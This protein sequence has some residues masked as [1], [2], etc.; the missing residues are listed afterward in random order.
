MVRED[1]TKIG[2][3]VTRAAPGLKLIGVRI[4]T[5]ASG[6]LALFKAKFTG[7]LIYSPAVL[8]P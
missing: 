1:N 6:E 4:T 5:E 7:K 3:R 2:T 8:P